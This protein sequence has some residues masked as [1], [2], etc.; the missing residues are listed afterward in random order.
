[1]NSQLYCLT[2]LHADHGGGINFLLSQ[3]SLMGLGTANIMLPEEHLEKVDRLLKI[4]MEIEE[5]EYNYKLIP[6]H[7]QQLFQLNP[8]Y[9]IRPFATTHR[10][11]SYGYIVYQCKKRL[12][13]EYQKV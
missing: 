12:K 3:R 9:A 7:E 2:H 6:S 11:A 4:W 5:F 13:K 1:M 8:Q 10:I